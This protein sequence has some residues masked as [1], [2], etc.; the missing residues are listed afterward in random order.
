MSNLSAVEV[1]LL[2]MELIA[3]RDRGMTAK[4][5]VSLTGKSLGTVYNHLAT[6]RK[7]GVIIR[8]SGREGRYLISREW[9]AKMS[10]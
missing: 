5:L 4:E 1:T 10:A 8:V 3:R 9:L 2:I 7:R 6:L